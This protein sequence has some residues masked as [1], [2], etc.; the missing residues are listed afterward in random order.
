MFQKKKKNEFTQNVIKVAQC[1]YICSRFL[2]KL[3]SIVVIVDLLFKQKII[4]ML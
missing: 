2:S 4:T 3:S 1:N